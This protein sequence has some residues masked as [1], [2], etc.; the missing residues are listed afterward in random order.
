MV[1]VVYRN[2]PLITL[3]VKGERIL[4]GKCEKLQMLTEDG[5]EDLPSS[6]GSKLFSSCSNITYHKYEDGTSKG[7]IEASDCVNGTWVSGLGR[8]EYSGLVSK[9]EE[10]RRSKANMVKS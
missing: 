5:V 7:Y 4:I 1:V 9:Y 3:I 8:E 2:F 6:G 10:Q